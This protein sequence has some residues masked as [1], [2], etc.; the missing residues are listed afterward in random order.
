M[1]R[2]A[3]FGIAGAAA[4]LAGAAV[5]AMMQ[6]SDPSSPTSKE[7]SVVNTDRPADYDD[8]DDL[9]DLEEP[10]IDGP[11]PTSAKDFV[12]DSRPGPGTGPEQ[13]QPLGDGPAVGGEGWTVIVPDK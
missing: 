3:L 11:P 5:V 9:A 2:L 1:R 6:Q 13:P 8:E 4:I 10:F 7:H 12:G